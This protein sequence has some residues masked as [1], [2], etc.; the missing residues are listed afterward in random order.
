MSD[1][2]AEIGEPYV[3]SAR[4]LDFDAFA[5]SGLT[6][7]ERV[8]VLDRRARAQSRNVT[9]TTDWSL[10]SRI[11]QT[12]KRD[13]LRICAR[14]GLHAHLLHGVDAQ[15][16]CT[17]RRAKCTGNSRGKHPVYSDWETA[18]FNFER[19]ELGLLEEPDRNLGLRMGPQPA[20]FSLLCVDVDGP[21]SLLDP[22]EAKFGPLPR[23]LTATSGK[24]IHLFFKW[25]SGEEMPANT[26]LCGIREIDLRS[27]R[28]QVVMAPSRHYSGRVYKWLD[29]IEPAEFPIE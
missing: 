14:L 1:T 4:V 19:I 5:L 12:D 8:I 7:E 28:G 13:A 24:G 26:K 16:R 29:C 6:T 10:L 2:C 20:G 22:L 15:G 11:A 18:P 27:R 23:T 17:C 3:P 25:P 9:P 21:R